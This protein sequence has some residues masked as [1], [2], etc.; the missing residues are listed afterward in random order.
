MLGS[1]KA[2]LKFVIAGDHNLT[3]D[4][5]Y[6]QDNLEADDDR[7]EHQRA[8]EIMTGSLAKEAGVTYLEEDTHSFTLKSG[9]RFNIYASAFCGCAFAYE[10]MEDRY[11]GSALTRIRAISI[12]KKP[13]PLFPKVD[14]VMAHGPPHCILDKCGQGYISCENL[15]HAI[16]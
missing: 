13:I 5:K 6:W 16:E 8:I 2:E 1:I 11:S 14:I 7:N 3:L 12:A 15:R 10:R 4:G 9:A